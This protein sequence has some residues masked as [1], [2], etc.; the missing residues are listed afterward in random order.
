MG[1]FEELRA[2]YAIYTSDVNFFGLYSDTF[3]SETIRK[4]GK[5]LDALKALESFY[6]RNSGLLPESP[7]STDGRRFLKDLTTVGDAAFNTQLNNLP[8]DEAKTLLNAKDTAEKAL[9][10]GA[11]LFYDDAAK[12]MKAKKGGFD[13]EDMKCLSAVGE[14]YD[15]FGFE[16]I[17][18]TPI[19]GA[20][21]TPKQQY[22]AYVKERGQVV[23]RFQKDQKKLP[24]DTRTE[25]ERY[26]EYCER[27]YQD[28]GV[29][30]QKN[31]ELENR[32]ER[33]EKAKREEEQERR[34]R[35]EEQ[36]VL[37]EENK[38]KAQL[39]ADQD[40]LRA[41]QLKEDTE[42]EENER[43]L[44][45]ERRKKEEQRKALPP[46]TDIF[47][48]I[49][50]H[51][52]DVETQLR[53]QN[54]SDTERKEVGQRLYRVFTAAW[55]AIKRITVR[56]TG[57][58]AELLTDTMQQIDDYVHN[59]TEQE[60]NAFEVNRKL[61][62]GMN[63]LLSD[64][65]P[66]LLYENEDDFRA[67]K[68]MN[69][70]ITF[71]SEKGKQLDEN[72]KWYEAEK[73]AARKMD[74]TAPP[75]EPQSSG[76]QKDAQTVVPQNQEGGEEGYSFIEEENDW[77]D[78]VR[79]S[80]S[81]D[82]LLDQ[83]KQMDE[84]NDAKKE[85]EGQNLEAQGDAKKEGEGKNLEEQG[86]AKKED[87][88]KNLEEQGD[89]KKEGE[90]QNLEERDG[91]DQERISLGGEPEND[92]PGGQH[93]EDEINTDKKVV[94]PPA[95]ALLLAEEDAHGAQKTAAQYAADL[96]A[97]LE[98]IP[99]E[100]RLARLKQEMLDNQAL[101][102]GSAR[103]MTVNFEEQMPV[104]ALI[105]KLM[106]VEQNLR[107]GEEMDDA[108][109]DFREGLPV[110]QLHLDMQ[111]EAT[112]RGSMSEE[113]LAV[114]LPDDSPLYAAAADMK[115]GGLMKELD[116]AM[117][118]DPY[119]TMSKLVDGDM[120]NED[121]QN[122]VEKRFHVLGSIHTLLTNSTYNDMVEQPLLGTSD[123]AKGEYKKVC[124]VLK[125]LAAP[126]NESGGDKQIALGQD[127]IQNA[128]KTMADYLH[129]NAASVAPHLR[130]RF[131][132]VMCAYACLCRTDEFKDF[133]GEINRLRNERNLLKQNAEPSDVHYAAPQDYAAERYIEYKD[134]RKT[135]K[136][137][138]ADANAM[139]GKDKVKLAAMKY[140]VYA[141]S[142]KNDRLNP[143]TLLGKRELNAASDA[144]LKS[145]SFCKS[146]ASKT[147][148][149]LLQ[150]ARVALNPSLKPET[151]V[152]MKKV[153]VS[154]LVNVET[155]I[156]ELETNSGQEITQLKTKQDV[157]S[158]KRLADLSEQCLVKTAA[159]RWMASR[160][161][162]GGIGEVDPKRIDYY[163]EYLLEHYRMKPNG[164]MDIKKAGLL[165]DAV[166]AK[167]NEQGRNSFF[168]MVDSNMAEY[169][170][171]KG[172]APSNTADTVEE[173]K[174]IK[175]GA[176]PIQLTFGL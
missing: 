45:E 160:E 9:F 8:T 65:A 52:R 68:Q 16:K 72:K 134:P 42:K 22:S 46:R 50:Y 109:K 7:R 89:A 116:W 101:L 145:E 102:Q 69:E 158:R 70:F 57:G 125:T 149:E 32:L 6:R 163:A 129:K 154:R 126:Y 49:A 121:R 153:N 167:Q 141:L 87:E 86:D 24:K 82:P 110:A 14:L 84:Q 26:K 76:E 156:K 93:D 20:N 35:I 81:E 66:E 43:K 100:E 23:G 88:G 62:K 3:Q 29:Y 143:H 54:V 31:R 147:P 56:L 169:A 63:D 67:L 1:M 36:R 34:R 4:F 146:V 104:T 131:D 136:Q 114:P 166:S 124:A 148:E 162:Y 176:K 132:R 133:C 48:E 171:K 112:L 85:G 120:S 98:K 151:K 38:K 152:E 97:Y 157:D 47:Y 17:G 51:G 137:L 10:A 115:P 18:D 161:Y 71:N 127:T 118:S 111:L 30:Q 96:R 155:Y 119:R 59:K 135:A 60:P 79:Y 168:D 106:I 94:E 40:K 138:V 91:M 53:M 150:A 33:E 15:A 75:V 64:A 2:A 105:T 73:I 41:E 11:M 159:A 27:M 80:N 164:D 39:K 55:D 173:T 122:E 172:L 21:M 142:L 92:Q 61:N 12:L 108:E 113:F 170:K 140:A 37:D 13:A 77:E 19:Q 58:K 44:E 144:L 103:G 99:R 95:E 28:Y 90:G 83:I 117:T 123:P 25:Q 107:V 128:K 5:Y 174:T 165:L 130:E 74:E 175:T 139:G 78:S